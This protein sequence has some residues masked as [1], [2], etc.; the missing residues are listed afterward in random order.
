MSNLPMAAHF[1]KEK[2][3][4]IGIAS[5]RNVKILGV[6]FTVV[7]IACGTLNV[8]PIFA[9]FFKIFFYRQSNVGLVF[10]FSKSL[11]LSNIPP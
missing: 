6:F 5:Y 2:V 8:W 11:L 7:I 4:L 10:I 1:H 9:I 3:F